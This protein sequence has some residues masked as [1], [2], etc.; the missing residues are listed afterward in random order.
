M[1]IQLSVVTLAFF[2]LVI[3]A[4][5]QERI[6]P[7]SPPATNPIVSDRT[8]ATSGPVSADNTA[9]NS[10]S[11]NTSKPSVA[12]KDAHNASDALIIGAG[13]LLDVN[14][15]GAPD[16]HHE[17]RVA[18]SGDVSLPLVGIVHV[19]GTTPYQAEQILRKRLS[20]GGFFNNP[21]V[22]VVIKE[23]ST[24]GIS[25]MGEVQRPGI[26]PLLGP[27]SV[28]DAISAA[29]GA[30]PKA[31]ETVSVTHRADPLQT[32]V[33]KIGS[34]GGTRVYPG[35]IVVVSKAGVVYVIGDVRLPGG[36]V[37]EN[38]HLTVLQALALAQGPNPTAKL[39]GASLIRQTAQGRTETAVPLKDILS[40]KTPD[41]PI[42][43]NDIL[44]VPNS[45]AKSAGK[46][47]LDAIV[48]VATGIAIYRP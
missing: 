25:V 15:F 8:P 30:T 44:F 1:R 47:S 42:K 21:Q 23:Y 45:A 48:Q 16:F 7:A 12:A 32:D 36:F 40:S 35:D 3:A 5:P 31:G 10:A 37:M 17:V 6:A 33:V 38:P 13:D 19:G 14:V 20:D 22:S 4:S 29:G 39:N 26:Y 28:L 41:L 27:R 9:L 34:A 24:Q 43:P 2:V 46:R 11:A 18:E